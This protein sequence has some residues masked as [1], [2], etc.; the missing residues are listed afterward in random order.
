M[1]WMSNYI[2]QKYRVVIPYVLIPV[3]IRGLLSNLCS[4][5]AWAVLDSAWTPRSVRL[6]VTRVI[7]LA[8]FNQV[9][10][11]SCKSISHWAPRQ[12]T[13]ISQMT[14]SNA[15]SWMKT[16]EF[17]L[18]LHWSLSL[19]VQINNI[20][21]LVQIMLGADQATNHYLNQCW[22]VYWRIYAS[23]SFNEINHIKHCLRQ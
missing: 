1:A 22:S 11:T 6:D 17:P 15:F 5:S 23:L 2:S 14:F 10:K 18:R 8:A 19:K 9:P 12:V 21:T 13:T 7:V 3:N 16:Y 4:I 20:P